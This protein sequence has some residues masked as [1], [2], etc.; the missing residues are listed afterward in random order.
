[1]NMLSLMELIMCMLL[2]V[3]TTET[4]CSAY[5]GGMELQHKYYIANM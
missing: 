4:R 3:E 1:M 5:D 2:L